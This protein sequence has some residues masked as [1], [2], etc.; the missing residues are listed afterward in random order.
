MESDDDKI[1]RNDIEKLLSLEKLINIFL[2]EQIR[3]KKAAVA[4]DVDGGSRSMNGFQDD[5]EKSRRIKCERIEL[6]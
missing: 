3:E 4:G 2:H 6:N 1:H 5:V